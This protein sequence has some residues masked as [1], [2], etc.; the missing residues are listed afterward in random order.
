MWFNAL[1]CDE[2]VGESFRTAFVL[3]DRNRMDGHI[4]PP[5]SSPGA[6]PGRK[7]LAWLREEQPRSSK[8]SLD[9]AI[10]DMVS[11]WH[12]GEKAKSGLVVEALR[13]MRNRQQPLTEVLRLPPGIKGVRPTRKLRPATAPARGRTEGLESTEVQTGGAVNESISSRDVLKSGEDKNAEIES[14]IAEGTVL[15]ENGDDEEVLSGEHEDAEHEDAQTGVRAEA[16][17]VES[18]IMTVE[19][20]LLALRNDVS[21]YLSR[22]KPDR[23]LTRRMA[24]LRH[25]LVSQEAL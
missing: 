16:P 17:R 9:E 10:A 3:G 25:S 24:L 12:A 19:F 5:A 6:T 22:E 13:E 1:R 14:E 21:G 4:S 20:H 18:C 15:V 11:C 7:L 2:I 8:K 23:N